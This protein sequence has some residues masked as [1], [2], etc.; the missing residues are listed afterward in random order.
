LV[1][2]QTTASAEFQPQNVGDARVLGLEFEFRK[3]LNFLS[4]SLT[5]WS[6][7]GNVTWVDSRVDMSAEELAGREG[8]AR[9][10]ETIDETRDMQG[11][12]PY[13]INAGLSYNN[14]D[15]G[16][17][18][19]FFYNVQGET[20]LIVA[21]PVFPDVYSEPFHSLNFNANKSFGK[22]Q[23]LTLNLSVDNIL[24]DRREQ[25]FQNFEATDQLFYAFDPG[26]EIG[27]GIKYSF[28]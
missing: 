3:S 21:S 19:G 20:L 1:R 13:V 8:S 10:G 16:L 27:V 25:F 7:N 12:A 23:R 22:D 18:A 9:T 17:D 26:V 5:N 11:Q 2:F 15:M 24:N 28:F 4:E 6:V 14:Y